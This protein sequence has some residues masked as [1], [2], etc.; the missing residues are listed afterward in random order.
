MMRISNVAASRSS[1]SGLDARRG[2]VAL[3]LF[4]VF[5][6]TMAVA[7]QTP[8][9]VFT[10]LFAY[11]PAA[12]SQLLGKWRISSQLDSKLQP[13]RV[14]VVEDPI[15]KTVGRV[16]V[17][18]GDG[19]E[20]ASDAML[21]ARRYVCDSK[22]SRAAAMEAE[23]GGVVPSERTEIQVR[24]DRAT[25]AGELVKFGQP[26]WYR[27]SFKIAGDW[28]QDVPAAGRQP[29]RTVI[30]QIKQDSFTDG[31]SCNASPFFKI[32]AQPLGERVRFFA[33]V[34]AGAPCAQPPMV[35][36]TQLCRRDLPRESWTTV[37]V[38][39]NPTHDFNDGRVDIWL[40]GEFCGTYQ[41]PMADPDHGVRR[42]GTPFINAQPRFGIYRDW[43]AETQT[44]YFDKIMFWNA[45]PEG[46]PDWGM[47]PPPG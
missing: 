42:N 30:H 34:A 11:D 4:A 20:G 46:H 44:I 16:T 41:G 15:G 28:P 24:S 6:S 17:Q 14:G 9:P 45:D 26:V 13:L 18:E 43:R 32:E 31:K 5:T 36:R 22:G 8:Q 23:P 10:E 39:L 12:P 21:R 27:F 37:Q 19:L 47:K 3:L 29:C 1:S 25:G 7:Q 33:Q 38:R 35:M 2:A 40:K